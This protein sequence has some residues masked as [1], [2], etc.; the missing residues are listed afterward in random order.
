MPPQSFFEE[1]GYP[2]EYGS[3]CS[4]WDKDAESCQEGGDDHG[5]DWC[6]EAWCYVASDNTCDPAAY[7][8]VFFA[9]TEYAETLKFAVSACADEEAGSMGLMSA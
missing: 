8:T 7:D 2:A 9:D 1:K 5:K 4:D 6:T 3:S